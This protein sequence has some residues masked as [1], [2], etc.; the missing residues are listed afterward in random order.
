[1][2]HEDPALHAAGETA[3]GELE[4]AIRL[5]A[6]AADEPLE[7]DLLADLVHA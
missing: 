6:G 3:F 4:T 1:L 5:V 7:G 2:N